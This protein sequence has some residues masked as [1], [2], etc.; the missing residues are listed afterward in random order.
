M[1]KENKQDIYASAPQNLIQAMNLARGALDADF[2]RGDL[3]QASIDAAN[4][5]KLAYAAFY[6]GTGQ[7]GAGE[8]E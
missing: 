6:A 5:S 8:G 2:R 4:V 7:T 3:L 1:E